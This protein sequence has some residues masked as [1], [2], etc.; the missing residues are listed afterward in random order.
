MPRDAVAI[1]VVGA[2]TLI[3]EELV[4]LLGERKF[5]V[6]EIRLLGTTRTAG[7]KIDEVT[8]GLVGQSAFDGIDVAFFAAGPAVSGEH[9]GSALR[10]GAVVIDASSRFRLEDTVPLVVPEV[11]AALLTRAEPP[12][13]V[14]TPSSTAVGLAV[15]LAPLVEAAG[16]RR[17]VVS[18]YQSAA[19]AGRR[20]VE[21]LSRESIALLSGRGEDDATQVRRAFNCIPQV[22][23]VEIDGATTYE[24]A[25][26]DEV[27]KI[28]VQPDLAIHVTAVRVPMFFGVAASVAVELER[29]LGLEAAREVLRDGRG[30]LLHDDRETGA[31]TPADVIGSQA[32]HVGR[33]REDPTVPGGLALWIA[34]D[35]I[36]KGVALNAVEIA[37]ILIRRAS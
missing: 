6:G 14:A 25:V 7:R 11:N 21:Y 35:S 16:V 32:T 31:P 30:I 1:A 2:T 22:G 33:V 19:G 18:T 34:L 36:E 28:L 37:E 23:T 10:A 9:V 15:V 3:G 24:Q 26:A 17:V 29:P 27:R 5:P 4:R 8:V 12:R 20:A 13:L